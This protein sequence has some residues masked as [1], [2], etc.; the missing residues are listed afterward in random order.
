MADIFISYSK[1]ER[2][3]TVALARDLEARGYT[4]WWDTSLLAGDVFKD[5]ILAELEKAKVAIVIW[6]RSS[7]KSMWVNSEARR[8]AEA[9]KLIPLRASNIILQDIPPPFDNYQTDL[10]QERDK[11]YAAL[12]KRGI[13]TATEAAGSRSEQAAVSQ[14]T[15]HL[16]KVAVDAKMAAAT[17]AEPHQINAT[18]G[19]LNATEASVQQVDSNLVK[20]WRVGED[21]KIF[22]V[23]LLIISTISMAILFYVK[24]IEITSHYSGSISSPLKSGS[25]AGAA[26]VFLSVILPSIIYFI[27]GKL[28]LY[29]FI[30]NRYFLTLLIIFQG[31]LYAFGV[32]YGIFKTH[33]IHIGD[34]SIG[35]SAAVLITFIYLPVYLVAMRVAGRQR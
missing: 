15:R 8:A 20:Y 26:A 11:V 29:I 21:F 14:A 34:M 7:V 13:R 24:N 32:Y 35:V 25:G 27:M 12:I 18:A 16:R 31:V 4:V 28:F 22:N 23:Y 3:L 10:V 5:V 33:N 19:D 9:G 30:Y 17:G 2:D 1:E 6:T